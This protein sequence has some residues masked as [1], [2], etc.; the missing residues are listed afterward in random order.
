[1]LALAEKIAKDRDGKWR[2]FTPP[3]RRRRAALPAASG[4]QAAG[5]VKR[6][7]F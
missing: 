2:L 7:H 4:I 1:M 6:E 3:A 5:Y